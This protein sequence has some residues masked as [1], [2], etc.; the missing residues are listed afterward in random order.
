MSFLINHDGIA[1]Q[2]NLGPATAALA[3]AMTRFDPD[4]TWTPL[5]VP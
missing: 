4:A 2:K 1:Y 5:P 3:S